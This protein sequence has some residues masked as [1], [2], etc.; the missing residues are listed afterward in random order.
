MTE[1]SIHEK[2]P[3]GFGFI[4]KIT[5]PSG[6]SYIGQ[7]RCSVQQRW[8]IH[9]GGQKRGCPALFNAIRKYGQDNM[10]VEIM[11]TVPVSSLN[12]EETKAITNYNSMA[13]AGY[14]LNEG[15]GNPCC[16]SDE[17]KRKMSIARERFVYTTEHRAKLSEANRRRVWTEE[18]KR[19]MAESGRR[20]IFTPEHRANI[21]AAGKGRKHSAE[22]L[23]KISA[24][25]KGRI[26]SDEH[27][28]RIS[29][30][31][32]LRPVN[33]ATLELMHAAVR[34]KPF[35]E[36]HKR[37]ISESLKGVKKTPS[38]CQAMSA[39]QHRRFSKPNGG[40]VGE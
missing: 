18:T 31:A 30:S 37:R 35:T 38:H 4:Y 17:T 33:L 6:S 26:F 8:K 13:P 14:N 1:R 20:K 2:P 27:R 36:E 3:P 22:F 39:G 16:V 25:Q 7:T 32:K 28:A 21:S 40:K 23:S 9:V 12:E 15:G 24:S 11:S 34:G 10:R 5:S 29:A 19:K